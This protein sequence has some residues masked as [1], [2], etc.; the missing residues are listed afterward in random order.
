MHLAKR[1]QTIQELTEEFQDGLKLISFLEIISGKMFNKYE[2]K[3]KIRIQKIQNLAAALNFIKDQGVI[4]I[5][6][7][8]E[9]L[10]I[11]RSHL[12]E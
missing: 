2:K 12:T 8:A 4:L 3:P 6:I 10:S 1:G 5:S 11:W 9:G 7:S